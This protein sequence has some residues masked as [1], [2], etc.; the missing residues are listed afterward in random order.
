MVNLSSKCPTIFH[1]GEEDHAIPM[2][3]V[4]QL[5]AAQPAC[6]VH[7]YPAGHGFNCEQRGSYHPES[8]EIALERTLAHFGK[9][10][11]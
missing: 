6:Q 5:K 1:F 2:T 9:E 4:D 7:I 3:E 11:G 8:R 10:V